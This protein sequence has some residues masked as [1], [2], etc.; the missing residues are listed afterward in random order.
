MIVRCD[1]VDW[2]YILTTVVTRTYTLDEAAHLL[3]ING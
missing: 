2:N 1:C 3:N